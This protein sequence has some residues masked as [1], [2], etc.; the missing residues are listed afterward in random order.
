MAVTT[1][2][3][4]AGVRVRP[5]RNAPDVAEVLSDPLGSIVS[6]E[7]VRAAL[8][9]VAARGFRQAVTPALP[10]YEW[11]PYIDA[12][13]SIR[14]HLHLLSQDLLDLP[15]TGEQ[16]LVRVPRH[17]Y[18][19]LVRI[20]NAAFQPFWRMDETAIHEAMRATSSSRLRMTEDGEG[21]ALF[22]RA[23][24]R[25]YLQR[26]AVHPAAQGQG[27]G[28]R[29][30]VDGLRWLRRRRVTD[31]LVNTQESNGQA[32]AVYEHLGFRRQRAGLAVLHADVASTLATGGAP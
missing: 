31:V 5:W 27:L 12:G 26:L 3:R 2:H 30:V 28:T 7:A 1:P 23:G 6:P 20:D 19:A 18:D 14:E 29:L 16:R 17:R 11:R 8:G 25:G 9:E 22:G 15:D 4:P 32:V 10:A 13:F 21:Y 24:T